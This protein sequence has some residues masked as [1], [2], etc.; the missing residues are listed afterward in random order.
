MRWEIF[1]VIGFVILLIIVANI[2]ICRS[3]YRYLNNKNWDADRRQH[4]INMDHEGRISTI[5]ASLGIERKKPYG[6]K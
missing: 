4:N 5:E 2:Y 1:V 6:D 3:D